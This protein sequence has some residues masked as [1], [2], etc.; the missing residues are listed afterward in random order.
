MRTFRVEMEVGDPSQERFEV[1]E[2]L[3][4]SGASYTTMRAS[5]LRELGVTALSTGTFVMADGSRTNREIGQTW[6]RLEGEQFIVPVVFGEEGAQ[7]LLGAVTLEIFRLGIDPIT[8]RLVPVDG[9]LLS[10]S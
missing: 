9:L 3:V 10:S 4:D 5:L 6:V 7:P 8:M 1:V 2:A